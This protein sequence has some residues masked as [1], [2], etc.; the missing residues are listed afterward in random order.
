MKDICIISTDFHANTNAYWRKKTLENIQRMIDMDSFYFNHDAS[1][2]DG[3]EDI[4]DFSNLKQCRVKKINLPELLSHC[5][6]G[7]RRDLTY[8]KT[9]YMRFDYYNYEK[10]VGKHAWNLRCRLGYYKINMYQPDKN[11]KYHINVKGFAYTNNN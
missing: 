11:I 1:H 6:R 3:R 8:Q 4:I 2:I 5:R 10:K 9:K 7:S